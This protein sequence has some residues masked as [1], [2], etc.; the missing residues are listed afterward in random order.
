M[1]L[2]R[3]DQDGMGGTGWNWVGVAGGSHQEFPIP[4]CPPDSKQIQLVLTGSKQI[5][6]NSHSTP[7]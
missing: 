6:T 7:V 2:I 4:R 3:T 1:G 5:L